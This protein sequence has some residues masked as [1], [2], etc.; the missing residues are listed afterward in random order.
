MRETDALPNFPD[1][2][3]ES[4]STLDKKCKRIGSDFSLIFLIGR[5]KNS[6]KYSLKNHMF[7]FG[8]R[9]TCADY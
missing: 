4:I 9:I 5:R 2:D 1:L 8:D 3:V 7:M 6:A